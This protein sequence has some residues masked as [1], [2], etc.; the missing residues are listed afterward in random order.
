MYLETEDLLIINMSIINTTCHY[1]DILTIKTLQIGFTNLAII[2]SFC[3]KG[4]LI[5]I[6]SGILRI[7]GFIKEQPNNNLNI[8]SNVISS[9]FVLKIA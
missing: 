4:T 9:C 7:E 6:L 5:D 1:S 8:T 3:L 2:D